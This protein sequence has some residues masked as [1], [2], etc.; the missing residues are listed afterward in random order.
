MGKVATHP[1]RYFDLPTRDN[2]RR[3]PDTGHVDD[4]GWFVSHWAKG[5]PVRCK[6]GLTINGLPNM[7]EMIMICETHNYSPQQRRNTLTLKVKDPSL[8]DELMSRRLQVYSDYLHYREE[9]EV[10]KTANHNDE[11]LKLAQ[12]ACVAGMPERDLYCYDLSTSK[13]RAELRAT[14]KMLESGEM[15]AEEL[16]QKQLTTLKQRVNVEQ[17]KQDRSEATMLAVDKYTGEV[18]ENNRDGFEDRPLV[19]REK[20]AFKSNVVRQL[21]SEDEEENTE[22]PPKQTKV[23]PKA[24]PVMNVAQSFSVPTSLDNASPSVSANVA[25]VLEQVK[26]FGQIISLPILELTA[27]GKYRVLKQQ[28]VVDAIAHF[29][30][31]RP[32]FYRA[33]PIHAWVKVSEG[34]MVMMAI[35]LQEIN[36]LAAKSPEETQQAVA[37]R[38]KAE[39]SPK[40]VAEEEP[41]E[42]QAK[43]EPAIEV[44]AEVVEAPKETITEALLSDIAIA[45]NGN[46]MTLKSKVNAAH[47]TLGKRTLEKSDTKATVLLAANEL[48]KAFG[49]SVPEQP[50]AEVK[51]AKKEKAP[52]MK[53]DEIKKL[54]KE[55]GVDVSNVNWKSSTERA[56]AQ[57]AVEA[58]A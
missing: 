56:K 2:P 5:D 41:K 49:V 10:P 43:E 46:I 44:P 12:A 13:G 3:Y 16:E 36:I 40:E 30:K 23:Q 31:G 9:G 54:A 26:D 6:N 50:T 37:Y 51:E 19:V 7:E 8:H 24:P 27:D 48:L 47:K 34:N 42:P 53:S 14:I 55:R 52:A 45:L 57:A 39:G 35:S 25:K 32:M 11:V 28:A 22:A 15:S 33:H 38:A 20:Q 29:A 17:S 18:I 21:A 58:A 1:D 4:N